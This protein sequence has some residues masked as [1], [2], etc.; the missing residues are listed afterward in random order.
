MPT[1]IFT[2]IRLRHIPS[3]HRRLV[4]VVGGEDAD[5]DRALI[6]TTVG[7]GD[8]DP[9]AALSVPTNAAV[10]AGVNT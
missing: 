1:C 7:I 5:D 8:R 9:R 6:D 10:D 4:G 3:R 2:R